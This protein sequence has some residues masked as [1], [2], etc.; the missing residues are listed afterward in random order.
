MVGRL[1]A[2]TSLSVEV[3]LY[4]TCSQYDKSECGL[5]LFTE[6]GNGIMHE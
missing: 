5:K 3:W 6:L 2:T 4:R 1:C